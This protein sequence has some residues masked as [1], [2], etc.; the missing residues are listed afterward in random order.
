ML[1]IDLKFF[2]KTA[3]TPPPD[4]A[5]EVFSNE[6]RQ[7]RLFPSH[8]TPADAVVP[9]MCKSVQWQPQ[10]KNLFLSRSISVHGLCTAH[11]SRKPSR[12]RGVPQ[13]PTEKAL[14]YGHPRKRFSKHISQCQ[15]SQG[16]ANLRRFR[17][18]PYCN[19]SPFIHW[20]RIRFGIRKY[21]LRI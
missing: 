20:R 17:P 18:V 12:Y 11:I 5:K 10:N 8:G 15:Q 7:N 19:R 13:S 14:S 4:Q 9:S 21:C 3:Y 1:V 6:Y 2:L 16:L